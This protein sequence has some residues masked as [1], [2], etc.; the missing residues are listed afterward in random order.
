MKIHMRYESKTGKH[1]AELYSEASP[2]YSYRSAGCG[3]FFGVCSMEEATAAFVDKVDAGYF[4]PD[5]AKTKMH[6]VK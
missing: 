1:W 6:R 4:L 3:G 2:G 5:G